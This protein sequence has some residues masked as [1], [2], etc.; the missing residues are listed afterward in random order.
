MTRMACAIVFNAAIALGWAAGAAAQDIPPDGLHCSLHSPPETAAKGV[1]AQR[2]LPMRLFPVT[3]GDTY[4]GC[5][6]IWVAHARPDVWDYSSVTYYE[7]GSPRVQRITYPPLPVQASVQR[8]LYG[9]D[10][11]VRKIME[12]SDWRVDCEG[13]RHLKE[14][15][16]VIPRENAVWDFF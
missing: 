8:C 1:R 4:T 3:P 2:A 5:Q 10:G 15:L 6:W 13:A 9:A 12:G 7:N 11:Q 16:L 14:L